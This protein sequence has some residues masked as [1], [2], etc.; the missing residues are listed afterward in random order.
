[1]PQQRLL[2]W[3]LGQVEGAPAGVAG[4]LRPAEIAEKLRA[5]GVQQVVLL[6]A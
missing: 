3:I 5:G 6:L 1:L 2:G 4:L